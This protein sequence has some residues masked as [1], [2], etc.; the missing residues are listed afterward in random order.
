MLLI[1]AGYLFVI[2]RRGFLGLDLFFS[3]SLHLVLFSLVVFGFYA[4]VLSLGQRLLNQDNAEIVQPAIL[5]F[6]PTMLLA[7]YVNKPIRNVIEQLVYSDVVDSQKELADYTLTLSSRPEISTLH[8]I[9]ASLATTLS[10]TR[11][12]L[13]LKNETG[14]LVPVSVVGMECAP[15]AMQD[16]LHELKTPLLRSAESDKREGEWAS[17]IFSWA[18]ILVPVMVRDEQI[19]VLALSRPGP[20]GYFNSRQVSF[21][22]QAA[23][24]LAV[25]AENIFLFESARR[26]SRQRLLI[27]EEERKNLSRQL[28]DDPLQQVTYAIYI[29]DELLT[30]HLSP[31][32]KDRSVDSAMLADRKTASKLIMTADHLRRAATSLRNVCIGLHPPFHDQGIELAVQDVIYHF[33]GEYGLSIRYVS[34]LNGAK[35]S[36]SEQVTT[37]VIRVLTEALNNVVKHAEGSDVWVTLRSADDSRIA[38]SVADNGP[39]CRVA[40]LSF[41]ELMRRQHL[42]IVGMHEWA[43]E[44]DGELNIVQNE[45]NGTEVLLEWAY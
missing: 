7:M 9:V 11:A 37:A 44:I 24:V 25:G 45:P 6:L 33:E 10:S 3:R 20:D 12:T 42:G 22:T 31:N 32:G 21:L 39:G 40:A 43:Q 2:Y 15:E 38:L 34:K 16:E 8:S 36:T 27:Q 1:P 17:G 5:V 35:P 23:G 14:R 13:T 41:N 4:I 30:K 28:H 29:I 19:G 18:E 26:Q